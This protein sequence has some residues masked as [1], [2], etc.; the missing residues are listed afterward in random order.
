MYPTIRHW[1]YRYGY[2]IHNVSAYNAYY[3]IGEVKTVYGRVKEVYYARESDEFFLHIGDYY[4]YHD[5]TIVIPGYIAREYSRR[6][7]AYFT[8]EYVN[9]TGLIT[10]FE[11]KP[12]IVVKRNFQI[13]VY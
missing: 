4:P 10:E 9:V 11:G 3:H 8:K 5:F 13:S 1:E 6:P 12:E 2:R 7:V